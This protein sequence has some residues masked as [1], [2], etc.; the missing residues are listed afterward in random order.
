[1]NQR[2]LDGRIMPAMKA[3]V[4]SIVCFVAVVTGLVAQENTLGSAKLVTV[5]DI[6]AD[7]TKYNG[8]TV[9][10]LGRT[11]CSPNLTDMS[12]FLAEDHCPGPLVTHGHKWPTKIWLQPAYGHEFSPQLSREK[13]VIDESAMTDKLAVVRRSTKLGFHREMVFSAQDNTIAP[14]GW[15]NLRDEWGVAYGLV[16]FRSKLK[17]GDNCSGGDKGCGGWNETPVMLVFRTQLDNFRTFLDDKYPP[18]S[19]H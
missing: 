4:S 10:V 3:L 6:L 2:S 16:V 5:C 15:D 9:A 12:C 1:M 8:K 11:D 14:K 19:K 18:R 13:L 7:T 17:P